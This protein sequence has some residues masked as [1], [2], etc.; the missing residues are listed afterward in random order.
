MSKIEIIKERYRITKPIFS[1]AIEMNRANRTTK[2][3]T[4]G[5]FVPILVQLV[6]Y[7]YGIYDN[8]WSFIQ[9]EQRDLTG[10]D[11]FKRMLRVQLNAAYPYF[12]T[13]TALIIGTNMYREEINE[14]TITYTITKPLPRNFI[15]LQKYL[16]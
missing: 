16:A 3:L 12:Y 11:F 15:F 14:D 9:I 10:G 5:M 7:F 2:A 8:R 4:I 1:L 6:I 13:M